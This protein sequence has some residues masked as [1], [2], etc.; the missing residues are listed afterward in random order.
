[1]AS[2]IVELLERHAEPGPYLPGPETLWSVTL[3]GVGVSP[4]RDLFFRC[5][6]TSDLCEA[7]ASAAPHHA[8]SE[9]FDHMSL[10]VGAQPLLEWPDAFCNCIWIAHSIPE[11]RVAAFAASLSLPY[12]YANY[13]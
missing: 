11:E 13:G 12:K 7:L 8:A 2:D 3:S 4:N 5:R 9:L 1:M 10:Y 6:F